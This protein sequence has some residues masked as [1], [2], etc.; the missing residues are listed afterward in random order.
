MFLLIIILIIC[1]ECCLKNYSKSN[2]LPCHTEDSNFANRSRSSV[3]FFEYKYDTNG[4][5]QYQ[6]MIKFEIIRNESNY[7]S[8]SLEWPVMKQ[9]SNTFLY[10]F[11]IIRSNKSFDSFKIL[12]L[13]AV[14]ITYSFG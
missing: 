12:V 14:F 1:P 10:V 11:N 6:S 4:S 2:R 13:R 3:R 8:P 5:N 9:N 7:V